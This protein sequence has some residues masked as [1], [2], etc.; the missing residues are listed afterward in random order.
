MDFATIV[1][2]FS[3]ILLVVF[4]ILQGGSLMI[5]WNAP[6]MLIVVG[7]TLGA[8]LINY[9]LSEVGASRRY[10]AS[11]VFHPFYPRGRG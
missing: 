2:L 10:P 9:P 8:T 7:G 6:S 5:F 4:G 3:A 1:G 11:T